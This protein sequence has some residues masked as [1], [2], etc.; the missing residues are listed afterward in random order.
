MSAAPADSQG[1]NVLLVMADQHGAHM[2]SCAGAPHV[3][4]PSLDAL[5]A[6]GTR[7]T[8]AY[9]TFPL[10]VPARASMITGR[11]PHELDIHGNARGGPEPA[12]HAGSLG[13]LMRDAGYDT[14]YA[15]K[16]H[17]RQPSAAPEDG[18]EVVAP[19]GDRRL[20]Q[21]AS[22][23]L[24]NRTAKPRPFFLVVSFDDP[25]SIC[26]YARNQPMPYGGVGPAPQARDLPALPANHAPTAYEPQALR[27]EQQRAA[28]MYGTLQFGPEDWRRYRHTYARLVERADANVGAVLRGLEDAGLADQTIVVYTSDHGD[29]DASH[30]WNQKTALYEETCKVPLIV[31]DPRRRRQDPT[32]PAL[33]SVGIDLLPTIAG[34]G[35]IAP[36]SPTG[37]E[38]APADPALAGTNLLGLLDGA[39]GHREVVVETAFEAPTGA[40]TLG[41]ALVTERYKYVVYGWGAD[42]E[43]LFDVVNDPGEMR[44]LAAESA[45]DPVLE[46]LRERLLKWCRRTND[47]AF[48]KR[49]ALPST[50]SPQVHQDIFSVPY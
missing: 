22:E 1:P 18:F 47:G 32:N 29:G 3:S 40:G 44:N 42:R 10:C 28:A 26:E 20:A 5:A 25:H 34:A 48:L 31:R 46:N 19:F 41:R 43:Q 23:W 45:F 14:A 2:L 27:L 6:G 49:L 35:G 12:R 37:S 15:G 33:V 50:A 21:T 8:R 24:R 17:A 13:H 11:F 4:T 30:R 39:P 38:T 16:W 9:T 7:F 36:P